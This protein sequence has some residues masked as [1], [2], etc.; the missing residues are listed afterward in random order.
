MIELGWALCTA[1]SDKIKCH[2]SFIA[3]REDQTLSTRISALTGITNEDLSTAPTEKKVIQQFKRTLKQG[4]LALAHYARFEQGF[5]ESFIPALSRSPLICTYEIA[6]RLY[7]DL[8]SRSIRAVSGF[9]GHHIDEAKR[10]EHHIEATHYIWQHL[11]R[12]LDRQ[13]IRSPEELN[14]WLKTPPPKSVKKRYAL[15]AEVRL[16]LPD[17]PGIYKMLGHDGRILYVGKATSL[18]SRVNS[19]FR[20]QKTKGSRLNELVSQIAS[21]DFQITS[22]PMEAALVESDAIKSENPPYNRAQKVGARSIGFTDF[23]STPAGDRGTGGYG[24]F[25]SLRFVEQVF[26]LKCAVDSVGTLTDLGFEVDSGIIEQGI[27]LYR[28]SYAEH[29]DGEINWRRT[30]CKAWIESIRRAREQR[31][32]RQESIDSLSEDEDVE[33]EAAVEADWQ[34]EDIAGYIAGSF[35]GFA[36]RLHRSRWLNIM[37]DAEFR[38]FDGDTARFHAVRVNA[39][40]YEFATLDEIDLTA[41]K[42]ATRKK[43]YVI[44]DLQTYDRMQVLHGEVRRLL[45]EDRDVVMIIGPHRSLTSDQLKKYVFVGD[46]DEKN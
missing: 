1:A 38:W 6:R 34:P 42:G 31:R 12:E 45:R 26:Q 8:P 27:A 22:C 23:K 3:L 18:K 37:A 29:K 39:G 41:T 16:K 28:D 32:L 5:L 13:G 7:P 9:L 43:K 44:G 11:V 35:A 10:S 15:P 21:V 46:F 24:P 36:R 30:L 33:I 25:S 14:A 20:G 4:Q 2:S 19:Y 40:R 17:L